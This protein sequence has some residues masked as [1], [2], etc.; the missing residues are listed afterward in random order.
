MVSAYESLYRAVAGGAAR[1]PMTVI[2]RSAVALASLLAA[3]TGVTTYLRRRRRRR[4]DFRVF[5]LEYH[6]VSGGPE[7]EG[8]V[9]DARFRAHLRY[10]KRNF[11][12]ES[13]SRAVELLREPAALDSDRVVITFDDGYL[14]NFQH[15]WRILKDEGVP[16]A[17]FVTTGFLDGDELWFDYAR[18]AL[19]AALSLGSA[20]P[21]STRHALEEALG[22]WPYPRG[23]AAAV[24]QLKYVAPDQRER[25]LSALREG[26]VV[27]HARARPLSWEQVRELVAGGIEIGSHTVSHPILSALS[28]SAQEAE[29]RRSSDRIEQ[30]TGVRP[31]YFAFPNGSLRDFDEHTLSILRSLGFQAACT[32]ERGSNAPGCERLTLRRIGVGADPIPV[33]SARMAGLFD[34]SV[35]RRLRL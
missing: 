14:G 23:A 18:R 8:V 24:G 3:A 22:A 16:A 30:E 17:I 21:Q 6:D 15:A 26:V 2:R 34:E 5:V 19:P 20:L 25:A 9:S 31:V 27:E 35:R 4:G 32:T 13:L 7:H 28:P 11:R 33:L 10:L 12:V 29:I 1:R